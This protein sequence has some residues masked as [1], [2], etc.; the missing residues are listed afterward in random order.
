MGPKSD[1]KKKKK[2]RKKCRG[3]YGRPLLRTSRFVQIEAEPDET[4]EGQAA[5][6]KELGDVRVKILPEV[7]EIDKACFR[8]PRSDKSPL[9]SQDHRA[10]VFELARPPIPLRPAVEGGAVSEACKTCIQQ[11]SDEVKDTVCRALVGSRW[12][13]V[14]NCAGEH[15]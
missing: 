11:L 3:R 8:P 14:R 9:P 6:K 7:A 10:V 12:S 13:E 5:K 4:T 2:P 1:A 15:H